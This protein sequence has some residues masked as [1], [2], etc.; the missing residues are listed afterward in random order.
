MSGIIEDILS[1]IVYLSQYDKMEPLA[2]DHLYVS[3][4]FCG[5]FELFPC[6]LVPRKDVGVIGRRLAKP[7]ITHLLST[8]AEPAIISDRTFLCL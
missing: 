8:F 3:S 7:L 6:F 5:V 1:W 2:L 4:H